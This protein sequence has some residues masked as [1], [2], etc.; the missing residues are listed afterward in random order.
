M[1]RL[2]E[3]AKTEIIPLAVA[4]LNFYKSR[5]TLY[6][7]NMSQELVFVLDSEPSRS[8]HALW[9]LGGLHAATVVCYVVTE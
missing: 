5:Q 4:S 2:L 8:E 9:M 7:V 3:E 1:K 6:G